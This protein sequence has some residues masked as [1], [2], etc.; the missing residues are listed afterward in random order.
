MFSK[1][2]DRTMLGVTLK[3]D[4]MRPFGFSSTAVLQSAADAPDPV[5]DKPTDS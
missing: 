5:L 4:T 1:S 3:I 2:L